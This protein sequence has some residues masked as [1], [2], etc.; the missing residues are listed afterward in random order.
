[1]L[2]SAT[3]FE[4][5]R[6][7]CLG[8]TGILEEKSMKIPY[9]KGFM[10]FDE[11]LFRNLCI[12]ELHAGKGFQDVPQ[13][14]GEIRR[15]LENPIGSERLCE[16]ARGRK[17]MLV[18]TSDHTRPMPSRLTLPLLLEE[19]RKYNCELDV[20]ILIATGCHRPDNDEEMLEKFGPGL[21]RAEKFINHDCHD[22]DLMSCMG[23]LPSGGELRLN[24]LVEW[25]DLIVAE[26]FIEP[27]FFAGFSGGRK[28]ILPGIAD[29]KTVYSN[30]CAGFISA[31]TTR[32]G[33]LENNPIHQ[34]MLFASRAAGLAF[35]LNVVLDSGKNIRRA[36]A[37][38]PEKA[39][40]E[41]CRFVSASAVVKV[42]AAD[43]V[44]ASN[45]GYP[46]DQN[47]YQAVKG[48]TA[49]EACVNPGGVIIMVAACSD[50]IG[51]EGFFRWMADG[52]TPG[53]ALSAIEGRQPHETTADQW[54]AQIL[55]RVLSKNKVIL[56]TT[57]LDSA[58]V[59]KMHM[60]H[61]SDIESAMRSAIRMTR[62]DAGILVIPNGVDVIMEK[63]QWVNGLRQ[64]THIA[65]GCR[66]P[67]GNG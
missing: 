59:E 40:D 20:R 24:N 46:L 49:A 54:Q 22:P 32:A 4:S 38:H 34:D 25:A 57:M 48:M 28:S 26:G 7:P 64:S 12:I 29:E 50:G 1:M 10:E 66:L 21:L 60:M 56:V 14:A 42:A 33:I 13:A 18:I 55:A 17:R 15:S 51:G 52:E 35:I 43:I 61:A 63:V 27:H 67:T 16:M 31:D 53:D 11:T 47:L 62:E 5:L 45:G 30:H 9:H 8:D 2:E 41:G 19:A 65:E 3:A 6:A 36:F 37:G 23:R 39:H 58:M 44:L